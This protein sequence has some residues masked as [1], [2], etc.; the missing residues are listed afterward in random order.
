MAT[1]VVPPLPPSPRDDAMQLYRAFKGTLSLSLSSR[2]VAC[3]LI[4]MPYE[5]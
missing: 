1:L 4:I 3:M 5:Y 2:D